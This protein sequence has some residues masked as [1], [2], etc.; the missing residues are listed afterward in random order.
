MV[1]GNEYSVAAT[2]NRDKLQLFKLKKAAEI[3]RFKN[4]DVTALIHLRDGKKRKLEIPHGNSFLSQSARIMTTDDTIDNIEVTN[5][6]GEKRI[7]KTA[8]L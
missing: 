2:Q 3:I 8:S 4:D 5:R 1:V 7:I 6:K